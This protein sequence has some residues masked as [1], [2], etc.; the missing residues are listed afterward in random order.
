MKVKSF[1]TEKDAVMNAQFIAFE[2]MNK[3]AS[4]SN[5]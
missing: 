2:K 3:N 5:Y 1:L 4:K